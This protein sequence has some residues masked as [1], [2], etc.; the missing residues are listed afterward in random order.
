MSCIQKKIAIMR[1]NVT[2]NKIGIAV[3]VLL[4][5]AYWYGYSVLTD[6]A[7]SFTAVLSNLTAN[8][9]IFLYLFGLMIGKATKHMTRRKGWAV[10]AVCMLL[11][12]MVLKFVFGWETLL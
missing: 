12:T 2:A 10:W 8:F 9:T 6:Q 5:L 11:M 3:I 1:S 4:P 7:T